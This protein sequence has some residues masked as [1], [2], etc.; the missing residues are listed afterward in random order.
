MTLVGNTKNSNSARKN[1]KTRF[2]SYQDVVD[3]KLSQYVLLGNIGLK[4]SLYL[5]VQRKTVTPCSKVSL[6]LV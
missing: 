2:L 4:K 5:K 6:N 1:P 3:V